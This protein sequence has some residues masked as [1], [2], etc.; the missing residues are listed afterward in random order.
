MRVWIS[1]K[2]AGAFCQRVI[3]SLVMSES[4]CILINWVYLQ[5][6]VQQ[7]RYLFL[8]LHGRCIAEHCSKTSWMFQS[9]LLTR[10]RRSAT[11][12]M[13]MVVCS[14]FMMM[15]LLQ[16]P[17]TKALLLRQIWWWGGGRRE[18]GRCSDSELLLL[19]IQICP[20]YER[21]RWWEQVLWDR[22]LVSPPPSP[23]VHQ[24]RLSCLQSWTHMNHGAQSGSDP[25]ACFKNLSWSW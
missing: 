10:A 25:A 20:F 8:V 21:R 1:L 3:N 5:S 9:C 2:T 17:R 18:G 4:N 23:P 15:F 16:P 19:S 7:V 24:V 6:Y 13:T 14:Y 11:S 22:I 12:R